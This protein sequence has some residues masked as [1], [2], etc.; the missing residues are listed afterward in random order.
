MNRLIACFFIFVTSVSALFSQNLKL[1]QQPEISLFMQINKDP[2]YG[3]KIQAEES[4]G[5]SLSLLV[6]EYFGAGIG[7]R[8][9]LVQPSGLSGGFQ[10]RGYTAW[11]PS[12]R[13][14][15]RFPL[16]VSSAPGS[17]VSLFIIPFVSGSPQ[18]AAYGLID[19]SFFFMNIRSGI[20]MEFRFFKTAGWSLLVSLPV[21]VNFRQ[22]LTY[23]I[24]PGISFTFSHQLLPWVKKGEGAA[25]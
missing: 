13:L 5:Y 16:F 2:R 11:G 21:S 15:G 23:S 1:L 18:F 12:L 20:S 25:E 9:L 10:Y 8:G 24:A 6:S 4:G 22:D 3:A 17:P 7:V 19:R 14:F